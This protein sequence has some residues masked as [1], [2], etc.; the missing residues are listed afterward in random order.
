M[1]V[2]QLIELELMEQFVLAHLPVAAEPR[3]V[4]DDWQNHIFNINCLP[5]IFLYACGVLS[6]TK[7]KLHDLYSL[8][9]GLTASSLRVVVLKLVQVHPG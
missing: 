8:F 1:K 2:L 6:D 9:K 4:D 3:T 7:V 5:D